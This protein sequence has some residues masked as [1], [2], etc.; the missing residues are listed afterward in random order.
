MNRLSRSLRLAI[1]SAL[2][3]LIGTVPDSVKAD[4]D[5]RITNDVVLAHV[6]VSPVKL[7]DG[8][9]ITFVLENQSAERILF[10]GITVT[11]ARSSRIVASLGNGATTTLDSIPVAPGEVLSAD[12]EA[13]WIEV[14]G[15]TRLTSGGMIEATVS[16]G[17]AVIPISLTIGRKAGPST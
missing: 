17:T 4:E 8:A 7:G 2:L 16:F 15:L 3:L 13:L 12:G 5:Y 6:R 11:V 14:D 1:A 9:K 10:G